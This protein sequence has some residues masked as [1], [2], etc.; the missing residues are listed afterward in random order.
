[1]KCPRIRVDTIRLE[2]N[3]SL[4]TVL[5]ELARRGADLKTVKVKMEFAPNDD[6]YCEASYC[7]IRLEWPINAS[8]LPFSS[9]KEPI[10]FL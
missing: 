10:F 6:P 1:M 4:S 3:Q 7:D 8:G 9:Y 2:D 5:A